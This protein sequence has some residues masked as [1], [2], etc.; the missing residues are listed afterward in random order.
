MKPGNKTNKDKFTEIFDQYYH[1]VF[2]AV[3][4]RVGNVSDT[5][6]I[7][8]EVFIA[9][10]RKLDEVQNIKKWLFGTLRNIVYNY[11]RDKKP[12]K[13][14]IDDIFHDI[15]LTFVNGFRDAR[16]V[17]SAAIDE[18]IKNEEE[19][20]I[21]ELIAFNN[22]SY[23]YV[24]KLLGVTKRMI[25]YRYTQIVK[26]ILENLKKRGIKNIEDLL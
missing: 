9:L 5:E 15:S 11:Y 4:P 14:N 22:Y 6:D 16:I 8:Q 1:T 13:V 25:Q 10:Y 18:E 2:N 7:C 26:R 21:V 20:Q 23:T 12:D 24:A 19:R 3:Y 17:I